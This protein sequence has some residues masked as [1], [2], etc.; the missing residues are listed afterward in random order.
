MDAGLRRRAA[1]LTVVALLA[2]AGCT[3]ARP[4]TAATNS[5]TT[6]APSPTSLTP[7]PEASAEAEV[8]AA[9]RGFWAAATWAEAHPNRRHPALSK[10][11]ADKALAAEQ[12][13]IVLYRQQGIVS[14]GAPKLEPTIVAIAIN[15]DP[16]T[17]LI[18]DCV[19]VTNV[20]ASYRS[21]GKSALAPSKSFRHVATARATT[22]NG[23]WMIREIST[24]RKQPC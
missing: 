15:R 22:F 4:D 18:R 17:A 14:R 7:D 5:P 6:P 12:A 24:D 1:A 8:L 11:A 3:D 23:H 16:A 2:I 10:Y 20:R 21:T 19:D 9:Y 13:T